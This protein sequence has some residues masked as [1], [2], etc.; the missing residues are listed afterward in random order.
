MRDVH[1]VLRTHWG[2]GSFRPL[3]EEVVRSAL[4]GK[5]TLALLPTGGGKSLCYQVPA[6]AM[7]RL[8]LVVS[9]LIALMKDQV[10]A[11]VQRGIAAR[12]VHSGLAPAEV[13]NALESAALG[14]LAFLYVAPERLGTELFLARLPRMP[15]GLVA[16]DEAHCISQWGHDFRPAYRRIGELRER[17]PAVP[18][19]AL[20]ASATP[21]V[22][23]DIMDQLAFRERH[24]LR[25]RFHREELVFWVS[26]GE[27]KTGRLLRIMHHVPGTAIVYVRNRR[28]TVETA[29]LLRAHGIAAEAYHA[30]LP[31]E[32][33]DR[34]QRDWTT[35]ATRC[36]V[37]TNAFGMGIDK[38]DVRSVTHIE[39]P[40]DPESYYQEAGRGGRDG[41][42]AHAF[43][44]VGPDDVAKAREKVRDAFPDEP[45]VRRVY[46]AFADLHGIALGAGHMEAYEL[47]IAAVA[48]RAQVPPATAA[49]ALKALELDGRIALSDGVYS[50]SRAMVIAHGEVVHHLRVTDRLLGP[51]MDA[52]LR[53]HGGLFE[54][55]VPIDE[56]R[57]A[58]QLEWDRATVLKRLKELD[59]QRVIIYRPRTDAP[60]VTLLQPR[61][62]SARLRLDPA[63]LKDRKARAQERMEAMIAF[64]QADSGCRPTLLLRHFGV[65]PDA[66]CG[67]CDLCRRAGADTTIAGEPLAHYG[68]P[69]M[70]ERTS[71][72]EPS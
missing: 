10:Q 33:R 61:L 42:T 57:L 14:R 69:T 30:G 54:E 6:L 67:R 68:R 19:M 2:H 29:A 8:C 65:G 25:G 37:A 40:P 5:D 9:P 56:V 1:E 13:E 3:Q 58:R 51:L 31:H 35:G 32:E 15:L 62:D 48:A 22:A 60:M 7:G 18:V 27:D 53:A 17:V 55:A 26:H 28:T 46:Q 50:P 64:T 49:H 16:V 21:A 24:V 36:V 59:R 43:L 72:D 52:L 20:T 47:D 23:E 63:A 38:A 66:P 4:A 41:H 70:D 71:M 39:M 44:L 11:L 12:A 34:I 45:V